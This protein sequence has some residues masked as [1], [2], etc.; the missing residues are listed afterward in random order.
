MKITEGMYKRRSIRKYKEKKVERSKLLELLKAGMAAPTA[1]N[2]QPWH[3]ILVDD[4]N[5]MNE[6]RDNMPYGKYNAP[7][8]FII[9][10]NLDN[11]LKDCVERFWIQDCSSA[12]TNILNAAV[13]L[14]LGTVWLGISSMD[15][16]DQATK[17]LF[18]MPKNIFPMAVIYVGY[19]AEEKEAR[20]QFDENK[21]T[22]QKFEN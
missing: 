10:G 5:V 18:N 20:T 9:C 2:T 14:D 21:I 4:E 6:L 12:L 8:A 17:D 13:E 1:C 3:F 15:N 11:K 19:P 16:L 22:Y 7:A